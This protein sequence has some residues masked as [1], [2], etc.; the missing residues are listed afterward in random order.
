MRPGRRYGGL[1][2]TTT[3]QPSW[4]PIL[5]SGVAYD[6]DGRQYGALVIT[7][8][9]RHRRPLR[10]YVIGWRNLPAMRIDRVIRPLRQRRLNRRLKAAMKAE[11]VTDNYG[12][13]WTPTG[14]RSI[15]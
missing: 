1:L 11:R 12:G 10:A 6:A 9:R 8:G 5:D 7:L 2:L 3:I 4:A 13:T 15:P 14:P